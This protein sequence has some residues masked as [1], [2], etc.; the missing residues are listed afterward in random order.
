M[1]LK[2]IIFVF[3]ITSSYAFC[4]VD[5]TWTY[6]KDKIVIPFELTNNL[7]ILDVVLNGTKLKMILDTGSNKNILF[8]IGEK[9]SVQLRSIRKI[10]IFGVGNNDPIDALISENNDLEIK[11]YF[12]NNFSIVT[13][14]DS[15]ISM[16]N[17]FGIEIN[18][19]IGFSFFENN[20][21]KI[22]YQNQ[23]ITIFKKFNEIDK[24]KY[25]K[26]FSYNLSIFNE[27]PYLEDINILQKNMYKKKIKVLIDTGLSDA[28]WLFYK[29]EYLVSDKRF[30][31]DFLGLG[32][33]GEIFGKRS[34]LD[35][36]ELFNY[37]FSNII[38]AY[39]DSV[40][41]KN[42]DMIAGNEGIIGGE[43]LKRFNV[44]VDNSSKK[45]F[46]E[47]NENYSK[48]FKFNNSGIE[49]E[50]SGN[51]LVTEL[52]DI[53]FD[54]NKSRKEFVFDSNVKTYVSRYYFKQNYNISF[55]RKDSPASEVDLKVGDKIISI[56][57]KKAYN[58][59]LQ[60]ITDLFQSEEGKKIKME[61]E[62]EGK[63]IE[64]VFYLKKII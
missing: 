10:K 15:K 54:Y 20:L 55:I 60:K 47:E 26:Y 27:K 33:T 8:S 7:I 21:V 22:D 14:N 42:I 57:N 39:P 44:I 24:N 3:F 12:K 17:K 63:I 58:Y 29:N 41:F 9:D 64:V 62:R 59:T 51:E 53:S 25:K 1:T 36:I 4:Q 45:I 28:F 61:V 37:E 30:I 2:Q 23:K 46:F 40:F 50:Y 32:L 35:K 11:D 18:G 31:D 6:K 34:R 13:I 52:V 5:S 48:P 43:I 19:I 38:V 16:F 49:V 56:N